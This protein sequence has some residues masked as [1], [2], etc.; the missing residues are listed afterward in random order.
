MIQRDGPINDV[1]ATGMRSHVHGCPLHWMDPIFLYMVC[2]YEQ[3]PDT[4]VYDE[5]LYAHF[6]RTHSEEE[7]WRPYREE[8]FK[9]QVS[10]ECVTAVCHLLL[11]FTTVDVGRT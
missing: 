7:T 5:P 4:V 3:R 11:F 6:L 8:V 9:T 2:V 1:A 10:T